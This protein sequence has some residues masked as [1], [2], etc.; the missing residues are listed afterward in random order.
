MVQNIDNNLMD[1]LLKSEVK[2][3]TVV[4]TRTSVHS[5]KLCQHEKAL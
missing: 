2:E 3:N 4:P 5:A 1:Y